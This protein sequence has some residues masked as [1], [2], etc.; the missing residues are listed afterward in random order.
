MPRDQVTL[1]AFLHHCWMVALIGQSVGVPNR[2]RHESSNPSRGSIV[3][4]AAAFQNQPPNSG[5]Q[6]FA[7]SNGTHNHPPT[8]LVHLAA[9]PS[10][11]PGSRP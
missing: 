9:Q 4:D 8:P 6:S 7:V 2:L 11:W 1:K 5:F 3:R 10:Q